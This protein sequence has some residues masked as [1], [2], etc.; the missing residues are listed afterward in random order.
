MKGVILIDRSTG[1]SSIKRFKC[2]K[3]SYTQVP[4]SKPRDN[5][6]WKVLF[7]MKALWKKTNG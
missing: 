5:F 7:E 1:L 6:L 2:N 4:W 3:V